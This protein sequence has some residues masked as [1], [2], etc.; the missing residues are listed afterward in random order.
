ME[1][2]IQQQ[3]DLVMA[4]VDIEV[5]KHK[6]AGFTVQLAPIV[7]R[8]T[9]YVSH[10][11]FFGNK[12]NW[13]KTE[14]DRGPFNCSFDWFDK[15]CDYPSWSVDE[16]V[17]NIL[18]KGIKITRTQNK[19]LHDDRNLYSHSGQ[20]TWVAEGQQVYLSVSDE[21]ANKIFKE[22]FTDVGYPF[23]DNLLAKHSN[24]LQ[25]IV[26]F[27]FSGRCKEDFYNEYFYVDSE[28]VG[29]RD[30]KRYDLL[31][32][33]VKYEDFDMMPL[34]SF[35]QSYGMTLA[36]IEVIRNSHPELFVDTVCTVDFTRYNQTFNIRFKEI[37]KIQEPEKPKKLN[38][39]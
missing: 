13:V 23:R 29:S 8:R 30:N 10:D 17:N 27:L 7:K 5:F 16:K 22:K 18:P 15:M 20:H 6:G 32:H 25:K 37:Q 3:Y 14:V 38:E 11:A 19:I 33:K 12:L 24:L 1:K 35:A 39:W 2:S 31:I 28:S 36:L 26:Q 34:N 4:I 9:E 21:C